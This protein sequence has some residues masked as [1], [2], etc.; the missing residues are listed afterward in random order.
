MKKLRYVVV[1]RR[2]ELSPETKG[3]ALLQPRKLYRGSEVPD[4][5]GVRAFVKLPGAGN[6]G[7][8]LR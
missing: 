7:N 3:R 4:E 6:A 8:E 2:S 1:E 5:K